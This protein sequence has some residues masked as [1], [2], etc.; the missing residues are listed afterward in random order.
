M[1]EFRQQ[2]WPVKMVIAYGNKSVIEIQLFKVLE[3]AN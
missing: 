3:M 2:F 1:E